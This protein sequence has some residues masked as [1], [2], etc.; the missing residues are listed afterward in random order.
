MTWPRWGGRRPPDDITAP[1]PPSGLPRGA[2]RCRAALLSLMV[3]G[4]LLLAG[5]SPGSGETRRTGAISGEVTVFAAASLTE[6]F[7]QLGR[8]FESAH[9]G[10]RVIFNF[11]PS[12][13]LAA[14]VN[15]GAPADVFASASAQNMDQVV[16]AGG[17]SEVRT[18]ARYV[19]QVVVPAA[20]PGKVTTLADL[21]RPG[22]T[23]AVCQPAVPCGVGAARVFANAKL[24]V[25]PVSQEADVKGVLTKVRLGEVDAGLVY[26]TDVVTSG[27]AVS[28]IAIPAQLNAS[29]AYPLTVTERAANP[30]A[31]QAFAD[32]VLSS[33]GTA[34]LVANGFE[35]P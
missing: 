23:V 17:A 6:S 32:Y 14:Q 34:V 4:V 27:G 8:Q 13:G 33:V 20:N 1:S 15:A 12:S 21:A 29:T 28:G 10:V 3:T 16:S 2:A 26:V 18:F 22:V 31:G 9:P 11:G 24:T 30:A 5:C 35:K 25:R 7:T 19:M